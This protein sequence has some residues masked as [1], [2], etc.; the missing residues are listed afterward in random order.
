MLFIK[1]GI[2]RIKIISISKII[3][4]TAILKNRRENGI[5]FFRNGSNPH[6]NG[7]I[8]SLEKIFLL[9]RKINNIE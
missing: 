1:N 7:L 2:G 9:L 8:F 6:S 3:K 4:I 5:R